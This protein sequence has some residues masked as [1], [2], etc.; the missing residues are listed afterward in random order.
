MRAN[1]RRASGTSAMPRRT[2]AWGGRPSIRSS[3]KLTLPRWG[4]TTPRMVFIVVDLPEALPPS[5]HTIS[6]W[7]TLRLMPFSAGIG[8]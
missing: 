4:R 2:I 8:P 1:R 7:L 5:R 3:S 6:P